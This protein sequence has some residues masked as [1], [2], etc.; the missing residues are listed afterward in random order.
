MRLLCI[1]ILSV[2][3]G[4]AP[5]GTS[6]DPAPG[7]VDLPLPGSLPSQDYEKQLYRF[8]MERK[9]V[10]WRRDKGVRDTGPYIESQY[11]GTHPSVRIYYSSQVLRWLENGR[12]GE[13]PDGA[14]IIKE[15]FR[16]PAVLYQ[17]LAEHPD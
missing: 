10:G 16:P 9:Y 17:E 15:M 4:C 1:L 6:G 12:T 14:M 11:F 7:E 3:C 5:R 2:T 8:L 13:I